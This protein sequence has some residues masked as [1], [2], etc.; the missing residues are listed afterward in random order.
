MVSEPARSVSDFASF[1]ESSYR[2][3][4]AQ[5]YALTGD[6]GEAQDLV[7][8]AFVRAWS[9]WQRIGHYDDPVAWVRTV[10]NRLAVSRWRKM[11]R[12]LTSWWLQDSP[13]AAPEPD[14][15]TV[16]LVT[17]LRLLPAA[18]RRAIVLHYLAD[19]SIKEIAAEEKVAEGTVKARLHRGRQALAV[20]L[21]ERSE[22]LHG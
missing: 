13:P 14:A 20:A 5:F 10:A 9:S 12:S 7:Q 18:Q 2:R 16:M 8:E 6:F 1:Y 11:R 21:G 4:V 22:V 3:V 17:A 15:H 19:L